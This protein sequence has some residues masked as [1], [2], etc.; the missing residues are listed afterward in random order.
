MFSGIR[1]ILGYTDDSTP[2]PT[3]D[4]ANGPPST[5]GA[6]QDNDVPSNVSVSTTETLSS[7]TNK[8]EQTLN[9]ATTKFTEQLLPQQASI[10]QLQSSSHQL[11]PSIIEQHEED[12]LKKK[13]PTCENAKE[14]AADE[15]DEDGFNV[16]S[17][18]LLDLVEQAEDA[19]ASASLTSSVH[20]DETRSQAATCKSN[21]GI[22]KT[23][24]T[25][26]TSDSATLQTRQKPKVSFEAPDLVKY[27]Q[28][29]EQTKSNAAK[30]AASAEKAS[31]S[32]KAKNAKV[33]AAAKNVDCEKVPILN[34]A[35]ALSTKLGA[36]TT[37][38][39]S[40]AKS[41][42][43]APGSSKTLDENDKAA[44]S[45]GPVKRVRPTR[46]ST[47]SWS[48]HDDIDED[49][50]DLDVIE[51]TIDADW[52]TS[53]GK[54]AEKLQDGDIQVVDADDNESMVSS[55]FSDCDYGFGGINDFVM[56]PKKANAKRNR[57]MSTNL[58]SINGTKSS[59]PERK[60]AL[61]KAKLASTV[62]AK[63]EGQSKSTSAKVH[64]SET[65][66][67]SARSSSRPKK[68][69]M[70]MSSTNKTD[71]LKY[72]PGGS[73][74][75]GAGQ[76]VARKKIDSSSKQLAQKPNVNGGGSTESSDVA[77]MD[78]SWFVTPPSCFTGAAKTVA[79]TG[80]ADLPKTKEADQENALIEH[81]SVYIANAAASKGQAL[82]GAPTAK[83]K[84]SV[85]I[86]SV[87]M[88]ASTKPDPAV[89]GRVLA[90]KFEDESWNSGEDDD[91]DDVKFDDDQFMP[92]SKVIEITERNG[93][94]SS[95]GQ[96]EVVARAPVV[97]AKP[98]DKME[99][100]VATANSKVKLAN[101]KNAKRSERQKKPSSSRFIPK[102]SENKA[103]KNKFIVDAW[104]LDDNEDADSD[105]DN[106]FESSKK[107][108]S[109]AKAK[110]QQQQQH[111]KQVKVKKMTEVDNMSLG[112]DEI[113]SFE[114]DSSS[115]VELIS[116]KSLVSREFENN[117]NSVP[118]TS[119]LADVGQ[120]VEAE[121][122]TPP[123]AAAE[124][125]KGMAENRR[126]PTQVRPIEPERVPSW[127]L[128]RQRSKR[129]PLA[130]VANKQQPQQPLA[131]SFRTPKTKD[132]SS[133]S[134]SSSSRSTPTLIDRIGCSIV[135]NLTNLTNGLVSSGAMNYCPSNGRSAMLEAQQERATVSSKS[136]LSQSPSAHFDRKQLS[137]GSIR[138][139]N[140]CA[141]Q[142]SSLRRPD[143]RLKLFATPNG[144]SINRKV[145]TSIH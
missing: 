133:A 6:Q 86:S 52:K 135:A 109:S 76:Q 13:S 79:N 56:R 106:M 117:E 120:Q 19:L 140:I 3:V 24:N 8:L 92:M 65:T 53:N 47:S 54:A 121:K 16:E 31:G 44:T 144:C 110:K 41:L 70:I 37:A 20:K 5:A 28:G 63:N 48:S 2:N 108:K 90:T 78:E 26:D 88:G 59:R 100:L 62:E 81:P 118:P 105:F 111:Q 61:A 29:I 84:L 102:P 119:S 43:P 14:A 58:G 1:Y 71:F 103:W 125:T 12:E 128:K 40:P 124:A 113:A 34:Y 85:G 72:K 22:L 10:E 42:E 57:T 122:L 60:V 46:V 32:K 98:S 51:Q 115:S 143:R 11:L 130:S 99:A 7:S 68:K 64:K 38:T 49:M 137:R 93:A 96:K 95:S 75:S 116:V 25:T 112:S 77:D 69:R 66:S 67:A 139:Q 89:S 129:R 87:A 123:V 55:S 136:S 142:G 134:A 74:D 104:D 145:H 94:S 131:G 126:P 132:D 73:K 39:K 18:E 30:A 114:D 101:K 107:R 141:K 27:K 45:N 4:D 50:D 9:A 21:S 33:V 15:D 36:N 17:W 82:D 138:R 80:K 127:L 91:E 35:K 97:D 23:Q 83:P